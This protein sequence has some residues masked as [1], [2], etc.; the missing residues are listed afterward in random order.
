MAT[1]LSSVA[2]MKDASSAATLSCSSLTR[3][4]MLPSLRLA[5]SSL[6]LASA[7]AARLGATTY[8]GMCMSVG[9]LSA[10]S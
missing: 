8:R 7:R 1:F 9:G 10:G 3:A 5:P 4:R 2:L 6:R